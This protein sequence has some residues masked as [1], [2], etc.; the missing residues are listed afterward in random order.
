[1]K[2]RHSIA[3]ST[4]VA[5]VLRAGDL[6]LR[7][8]GPG[9]PLAGIRIH[10][11]IQGRRPAGYRSEV[12]VSIEVETPDLILAVGGRIDGVLE[13][14]QTIIVEEIKST[15]R[16]LA[17]IEKWPDPCHWGQLRIYAHLFASAHHLD[18][19]TLRLTYC[20]LDTGDTLELV[21]AGPRDTLASFFQAVVE[22]YL[23]WATTLDRWRRLRDRAILALDFPFSSYRPGQRALAVAVY[24]ALRD[25]G[26]ALVQAPTGIGKTMAVLFPAVKTLAEGRIERIFFLTA[27]NTGQA[28]ALQALETLEEKGLR[29]KRVSLTARDRICFCPEAACNPELCAYARG[30]YDRL[31][32]AVEAAFIRDHLDRDAVE[33]VARSQR[34]C[35]FALSLDLARWADCIV[36]DYNYAFDPRVYLKRFFDEPGSAC[37][38][39]VDEAHNLVERSREMFSAEL[40]QATFGLLRRA[41]KGRLAAVY[42]AAGRIRTWMNRLR[43]ETL[44]G[45]GFQSDDRLPDGLEPLLHGLLR[46][47]EHWLA[48]NMAAPYRD[49]VMQAY[50]ETTGFLR[51]W[52]HFDGSY[53]TCC[54][55]TQADLQVKLFCLD[56]SGHLKSALGRC[57]TAIFFSA[58]LTPADYF[59]HLLGCESRVA[60]LAVPSPFAR[61]HLAVLI[62]GGVSTYYREREASLDRIAQLVRT[63]VQAKKGNYLCFFPS[64]AYMLGVADRIRDAAAAFD[65]LV[66]TPDLDDAGRVRFLDRFC[67][68]NPRTLVGFAVMGGVF[69]EGIDLVG[70]RLSGAVIVG[71]GLPAIGPE[72]ELI[73]S[74]FNQRG[75]GF[76]FAYR[77]PGINRVLQA[78]GRVIRG[79]RDRGALLLVDRRF[80]H[81]G[82]SGLLPDHWSRVSVHSDSELEARLKRFWACATT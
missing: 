4:L 72:R 5:F 28:S 2:Q 36:C 3:V 26:Q 7:F 41:V 32:A 61:E 9:R 19:V 69:G 34:V 58:T 55:A 54:R 66:Q 42:R 63:F 30:Y 81:P 11:L 24:R 1:M 78:A 56:P 38:F 25:G 52:E 33:A 23:Q 13:T 37:A 49:I 64:Y 22:R 48:G 75:A 47:S 35:P 50:F 62:A 6:D 27:R 74:Y 82:Y 45:G 67:A 14:G 73:R 65:I 59:Q 29:L 53:V 51:V 15:T 43:K 12:P 57:R 77:F 76:D 8:A 44:A 18:A 71:V 17:L 60:K 68:H 46:A 16:D 79:E 10:Q 40:N 20:H 31:P 39:L 21:E 80:G 70:E